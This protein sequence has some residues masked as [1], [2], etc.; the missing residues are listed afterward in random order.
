MLACSIPVIG[1]SS[2][3]DNKIGPLLHERTAPSHPGQETMDFHQFDSSEQ[4]GEAAVSED[5][6]KI[7]V[8]MDRHHLSDL[9]PSIIDE[10]ETRVTGLNG[11]IGNHAFNRVQVFLPA[12]RIKELAAWKEIKLIKLP[13][14]PGSLGGSVRSEGLAAGN[15]NNWHDNGITGNGVRAG[16]LDLGFS[17]YENLIGS[18]LPENTTAVY[19]GS[20]SDFYSTV[21]GTACA[22]ILH[23]VAPGADLYLVNVADMDVDYPSAVSWL[24]HMPQTLSCVLLCSIT[25][26]DFY[27]TRCIFLYM[28]N[29]IV[30]SPGAELHRINCILF[31]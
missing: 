26:Y 31:F 7:I 30:F 21:H 6:I 22:E 4:S 2:E 25:F 10:L 1:I 15:V 13:T 3:V 18:E 11:F 5:I 27:L 16:V 12:E 19:T 9:S 8:V 14:P 24:E 28:D 23:D 17:G 29:F 20:S